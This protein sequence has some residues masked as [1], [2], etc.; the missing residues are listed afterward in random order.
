M[1]HNR[2]GYI[3]LSIFLGSITLIGISVQTVH[4]KTYNFDYRSYIEWETHSTNTDVTSR[5]KELFTKEHILKGK[6]IPSLSLLLRPT[7]E[8]H[9]KTITKREIIL[10]P[11]LVIEKNLSV[12]PLNTI[13]KKPVILPSRPHKMRKMREFEANKNDVGLQT[14]DNIKDEKSKNVTVQRP[15][16]PTAVNVI[17]Q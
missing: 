15:K 11:N 4:N 7:T 5:S 10:K 8:S 16:P 1:L 9:I 17:R 3:S 2:I 14:G 6:D 13:S 12:E